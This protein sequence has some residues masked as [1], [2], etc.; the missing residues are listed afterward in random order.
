MHDGCSAAF[1][2]GKQ[3]VDK[4][5]IMGFNTSPLGTP[6]AIHCTNCDT[7]FEMVTMESVCPNCQMVYGVTPCHSNDVGAVKAAGINY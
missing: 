2:N 3:I 1:E 4:I 6:L 7:Q 5:R